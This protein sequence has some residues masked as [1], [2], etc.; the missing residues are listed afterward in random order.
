[1]KQRRVE[2]NGFRSRGLEANECE[3]ER[4]EKQEGPGGKGG[5]WRKAWGTK[6]GLEP[7]EGGGERAEKQEGAG[8]KGGLLEKG[9]RSK[10]GLEAEEG[11]GERV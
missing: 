1:L 7:L 6:R 4:A 5:W 10:R 3:G 9:L 11:G 8:S 2:E